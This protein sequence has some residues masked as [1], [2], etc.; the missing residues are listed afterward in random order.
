MSDGR[1]GSLFPTGGPVPPDLIV[2]RQGDIDELTRRV[3]EGIHTML[4]GERRIGKTT[5][6]NAVC[7]RVREGGS[8]VVQVEVPESVESTALLQLVIDR[9]S[10]ISLAARSRRLLSVA[11]PLIERVLTENGVPLDLSRLDSPPT[12]PTVRTILSLPA[13]LARETARPV[14]FYLDELQRVIDYTGGKLLLGDLVDLYSGSVDVVLLVDGSN[15]RALDG[16]MG[17]PVQFGKLVD[18]MSLAPVIPTVAWRQSLPDRFQRAGLS[19]LPE[20]LDALVS[21]GEGRPY[22]TMAAAR[23]AALNARKLGSESVEKFEVEEGIAEARR[24]L[25]EDA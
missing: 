11:R 13:S 20:A 19:L 25:A 17:D 6:C 16:M 1:I 14:V 7:G 3:D 9:F 15:D 22:P 24:H 21:F 5:V 4:T 23:Y 18:R 2:G 10:R 8:T 12:A